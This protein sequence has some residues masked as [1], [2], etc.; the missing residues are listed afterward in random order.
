MVQSRLLQTGI[1]QRSCH[2]SIIVCF[3]LAA[4][5]IGKLLKRDLMLELPFDL[6]DL[7]KEDLSVDQL[8]LLSHGN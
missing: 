2:L 5:A 1:V 8:R 6:L 3:L 7:D 4:L